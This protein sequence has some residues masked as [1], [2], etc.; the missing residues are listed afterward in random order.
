MNRHIIANCRVDYD[1]NEEKGRLYWL[2]LT[3]K[4]GNSKV[5]YFFSDGKNS[6]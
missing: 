4:V 2:A 6:K 3:V 5:S 1:T